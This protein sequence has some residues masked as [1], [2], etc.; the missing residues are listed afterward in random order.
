MQWEFKNQ[1]QLPNRCL[2]TGTMNELADGQIYSCTQLQY[3]SWYYLAK[4]RLGQIRSG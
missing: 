4:V 2:C 3:M 1:V